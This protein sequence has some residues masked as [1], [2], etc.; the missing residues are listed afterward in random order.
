MIKRTK[1]IG[2]AIWQTCDCHRQGK[3][4]SKSLSDFHTKKPLLLIIVID[5]SPIR[6]TG[7]TLSKVLNAY[8]STPESARRHL[9]SGP[10][11]SS[12][13]STSEALAPDKPSRNPKSL[14]IAFPL[15]SPWQ[16][17]TSGLHKEGSAYVIFFL[18]MRMKSPLHYL[19]LLSDEKLSKKDLALS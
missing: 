13:I 11:S 19:K 5:N 15:L 9:I 4:K 2:L 18:N 14:Q 8:L 16:P 1:Y 6:I 3:Y 12:S 10:P 7:V 17:E